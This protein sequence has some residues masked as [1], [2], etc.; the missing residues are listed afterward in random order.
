MK[1]K[2][3]KKHKS[4]RRQLAGPC[5]TTVENIVDLAQRRAHDL[6]EHSRHFRR[7]VRFSMD[8]RKALSEG[9]CEAAGDFAKAAIK[10]AV[11]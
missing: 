1:K 5:S 4:K 10:L 7:A 3:T 11:D 2:R 6:D 9:D 8:A